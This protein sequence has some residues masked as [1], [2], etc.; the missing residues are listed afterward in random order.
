MAVAQNPVY[1]GHIIRTEKSNILQ[2]NIKRK[3]KTKKESKESN[4]YKL[5]N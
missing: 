3:I 4:N 5:S 2:L 1:V